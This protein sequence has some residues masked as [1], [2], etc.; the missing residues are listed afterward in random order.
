MKTVLIVGNYNAFTSQLIKKIHIDKWRIYTLTSSTTLIKPTYVLEQF[1]FEYSSESVKEVIKSCSP[2]VIIYTGAYDSLYNWDNDNANNIALSFTKDISNMLIAAT[3][4]SVGHFIYL[5]SEAVFEGEY[6]IDI[7]EDM[8]VYPSSYKSIAIAQG[9]ALTLHTGQTNQM[10]ITVV[11]FANMYGIPSNR[12]ECFDIYSRMCFDAL[13]N[14]RL[15]VNAKRIFSSIYVKDAVEALYV[16]INAPN[17]KHNIYHISS[18]EEVTEDQIAS[19]IKENSSYPIDIIDQTRGLRHRQILSNE[20]FHKEFTI[21]IRNSYKEIVPKII[22]YINRHKKR[23]LSIEEIIERRENVH[24]F[25]RLFRKVIPYI[26][27]VLLFVFVFMLSHG[28]I[29]NK[30]L[31][32]ANFYMLYVLLF[33]LVYGRQQ[34]IFASLLS[35]IGYITSNLLEAQ[36]VSLLI[37]THIY[38]QIVQIFVVGLSVGHLRDKFTDIN[39]DMS[40]EVKF[41]KGKLKDITTINSSN[42]RIKE[43]YS[44]KIISSTES[45]GRIYNITSRLHNAEKGEV[46]FSALDTL[47]EIMGTDDVSIYLA[48]QSSYCRLASSS[49]PLASSL[50]KSI[51]MSNYQ[52]IFDQLHA[53]QV[54]I[55]RTLDNKLPMMASSIFNEEDNMRIIILIWNLPY[56]R[57][58]LYYANLLTIVGALVYSVFVRDANYLD[59]L[60]YKRLIPGTSILQEDAF[61]DIV[62]IY[63]RAGD[64]GYSESTILHIQKGEMSIMEINNKIKPSLRETDYIGMMSNKSLAILLTNSSKDDSLIVKDRLE[65]SGISTRLGN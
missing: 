58:T 57:M 64:K 5:S 43:Y 25:Y 41:L 10:E 17:R 3:M 13:L 9:E 34:A 14:G 62:D 42:K 65:R 24:H 11:R 31:Q 60:A 6:S 19:L 56:E 26:E 50:G 63:M 32:G 51:T 21:D 27:S 45:I 35:S 15:R 38:I 37:D 4:N 61:R 59:A 33:A 47:K 55:N 20:R 36:S 16:L 7:K 46:L 22:S 54:F 52:M 29:D 28:I 53:G 18:T 2:D 23:F 48:S 30:Y 8:T 1:V 49:S 44:D 12:Q 39:T 40:N